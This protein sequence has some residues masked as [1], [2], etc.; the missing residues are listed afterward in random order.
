MI[1]HIII[2]VFLNFHAF[3]HRVTIFYLRDSTII[4]ALKFEQQSAPTMNFK[5]LATWL[6]TSIATTRGLCT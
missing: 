6:I 5:Y 1:L 3:I 2:D 4:I